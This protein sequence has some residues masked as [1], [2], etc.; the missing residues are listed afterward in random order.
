MCVLVSV[1]RHI[2]LYTAGK[3]LFEVGQGKVFILMSVAVKSRL[4]ALKTDKNY[5]DLL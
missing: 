3:A 1:H 5:T 4:M 2:I